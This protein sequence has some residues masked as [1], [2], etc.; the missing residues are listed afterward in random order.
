MTLPMT[1]IRVLAVDDEKPARERL[2]RLLGEDPRIELLGCCG[3]GKEALE[4][5][6]AAAE[7]GTPV[8]LV[9]LDVQMPEVD[10]LA[11]ASAL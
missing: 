2:R 9:F 11:A 7:A 8:H 5:A 4:T 6:H 10:G 3:S 1:T